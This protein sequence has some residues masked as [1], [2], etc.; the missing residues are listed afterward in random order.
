MRRVTVGGE[1]HRA[2]VDA[3]ADD[4][5]HLLALGVARLLFHRSLA[6]DVEAHGTVADHAGDVDA[7]LQAFDGVEI[8]AVVFPVPR[9][10]GE[11]GV[12]RNVLHR[13]HHAGEE[14]LVRRLAG[15]KGD[16]A[17]AHEHGGDA[18]PAHRRQ[19]RIPANLGVEVGV[20]VDEAG[21]DGHA[22]GVDLPPPL[23]LDLAHLGD[24]A[25]FDG[26]IARHRLRAGAIDKLSPANHD[27]VH[28][29]V[30]PLDLPPSS[31]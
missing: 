31:C 29:N 14:F 3:V 20:Q 17:V 25:A 13:F 27:V 4:V 2:A 10:A 12:L 9:Q 7:G 5:R 19:R 28:W 23:A 11:D 18:V 22:L 1:A 16:A 21:G 6:H 26:D 15:R 8:A 30:P 24:A